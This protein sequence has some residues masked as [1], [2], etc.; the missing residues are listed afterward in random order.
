MLGAQ[1]L[2]IVTIITWTVL[3]STIILKIL[4]LT[5]G[6]RIP[7]NE[8]LLGSDIVEHA[9]GDVEYDKKTRKLRLAWIMMKRP[10]SSKVL[11]HGSLFHRLFGE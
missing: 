2:G 1:V 7:L 3:M 6:L 11:H 4:D 9:V 8:E 10:F 5:M